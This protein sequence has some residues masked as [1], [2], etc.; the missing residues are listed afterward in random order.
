VIPI[1][2]LSGVTKAF[3]G[4][5]AV[6]DISLDVA[7]GDL[8]GLIGP[9]GSGKT[10]LINLV[11]GTLRTTKG[12][13][14]FKG[15]DI[16]DLP[17][18]VRAG[19]GMARTFQI[20][21][22]LTSMTVRENVLVAS[23]FGREPIGTRSTLTRALAGSR[24]HHCA[25]WVDHTLDLVGLTNKRDMRSES[26]TLP[27]R[28]RLELARALGMHPE[29]LLLDEVMA[30]L[31]TKEIEATME[32]ICRING[33]GVTVVCVEHVM[34]AIMSISKRVVVLQEGKMIAAGAPKDI[35]K[36]AGVIKAY[37]G[38]RYGASSPPAKGVETC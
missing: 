22:P 25:E 17:T 3:G 11:T 30:G 13:I 19:M 12:K 38:T 23:L 18:H 14:S 21:K 15:R 20:V 16:T 28:K 8:L 9:N 35:V 2:S 33:T 4:L 26:L 29:L 36:D 32:L 5:V 31:N 1:L 34:K 24:V 27:D 10:T 37:L 6:N 7:S